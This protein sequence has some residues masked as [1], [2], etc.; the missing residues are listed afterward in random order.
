MDVGGC[1]K[2]QGGWATD[3]VLIRLVSMPLCTQIVKLQQIA[4]LSPVLSL[5]QSADHES[6]DDNDD[7]PIPIRASSQGAAC[8]KS[9]ARVHSF[10]RTNVPK[11]H[12][13]YHSNRSEMELVLQSYLQPTLHPSVDTL[14]K[15]L[16][17]RMY[18]ACTQRD[19]TP[20]TLCCVPT[21]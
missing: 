1:G 7:G 3:C 18:V 5:S 21:P 12:A 20:C 2:W 6:D 19:Q 10:L 14:E 15:Q 16:H 9:L 11:I 13:R 17:T 8:S 4:A